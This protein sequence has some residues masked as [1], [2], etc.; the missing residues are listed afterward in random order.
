M[1][2]KYNLQLL[3]SSHSIPM[4]EMVEVIQKDYPKM[5]KPLLSKCLNGD[6]Y[7]V[8]LKADATRRVAETFDPEGWAKRREKDRHR[9]KY[10]VLCRMSK[11]EFEAFSA[12]YQADGFPDANA[13]VRHA[14]QQYI[15]G[16]ADP[17]GL[18]RT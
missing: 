14:I 12:K 13:W 1:G 4:Q 9:L 17:D 18:G 8:D 2:T 16:E 7:G 3:R 10:S 11:E 6:I 15:R 5:D